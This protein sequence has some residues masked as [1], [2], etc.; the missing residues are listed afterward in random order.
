M[1]DEMEILRL[2]QATESLRKS[3][4]NLARLVIREKYLEQPD[5]F[6]ALEMNYPKFMKHPEEFS[7]DM[8]LTFM[9]YEIMKEN[10]K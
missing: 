1:A 8:R 9:M 4:F 3:A 7:R 2:R 10:E 5:I 6:K